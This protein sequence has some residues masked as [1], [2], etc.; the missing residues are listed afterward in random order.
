MKITPY[1]DNF[2]ENYELR[3]KPPTDI[4]HVLSK[5]V[6]SSPKVSAG[7]TA[8][9]SSSAPSK[10]P[11][12]EEDEEEDGDDYST[13]PS[14]GKRKRKGRKKLKTS[15]SKKQKE[16]APQ[17]EEYF[18]ITLHLVIFTLWCPSFFLQTRLAVSS[19]VHTIL[20]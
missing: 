3:S 15:K 18:I 9:S 2:Y 10:L 13:T 19:A 16:E 17:E 12:E 20:L 4:S 1:L 8:A 6:D 7:S 5:I 11:L 14:K